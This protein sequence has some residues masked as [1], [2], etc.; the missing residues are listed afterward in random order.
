[1]T[2]MQI[3]RVAHECNRAYSQTLG[4]DSHLPWEDA[5]EWQQSSAL[6][7]VEGILAGDIGRPQQAHESWLAEKAATGWVYG[8][9]KDPVAKTH[10]CMVPYQ[11]LP[12]AQRVKDS[13]FFA[14]VNVLQHANGVAS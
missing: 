2:P 12:P 4:D 7:G 13:L 6:K 5:P 11:Q 8:A 3:A 14:I 10:P 1:M 9:V